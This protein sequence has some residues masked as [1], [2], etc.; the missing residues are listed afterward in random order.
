MMRIIL[1]CFIALLLTFAFLQG[2]LM[3]RNFEKPVFLRTDV[4]ADTHKTTI[5]IKINS[6]RKPD[7]SQLQ[8]LKKDYSNIWAHLNHLYSSNEVEAGKE[9]YTE[10]WFKQIC[11]NCDGIQQTGIQRIDEQHHLQIENWDPGF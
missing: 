6:A 2:K 7:S 11:S 8:I 3:D 9:Y 10:D 5:E 4:I 1:S